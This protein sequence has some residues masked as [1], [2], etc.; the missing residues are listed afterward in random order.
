MLAGIS[1]HPLEVLRFTLSRLAQPGF[2]P[3]NETLN[4]RPIHWMI[5]AIILTIGVGLWR[6]LHQRP[7]EQDDSTESSHELG[8]GW[9]FI[10]M[11][12]TGFLFGSLFQ[13]FSGDAIRRFIS[14]WLDEDGQLIAAFVVPAALIGGGT[15]LLLHLPEIALWLGARLRRKKPD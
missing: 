7:F 14:P 12:A 9:A 1:E 6:N 11:L 10:G 8:S 2:A 3:I 5:F 15:T 4:I 13:L